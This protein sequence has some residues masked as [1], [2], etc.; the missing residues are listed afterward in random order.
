[1]TLTLSL[2]LSALVRN[3][4]Q[5]CCISVCVSVCQEPS[6]EN[7]NSHTCPQTESCSTQTSHDRKHYLSDNLSM[8]TGSEDRVLRKNRSFDENEINEGSV[9]NVPRQRLSRSVS[10]LWADDTFNVVVENLCCLQI[11]ISISS[12]LFC[13]LFWADSK[14]ILSCFVYF[15][16]KTQSLAKLYMPFTDTRL[17]ARNEEWH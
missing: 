16:T 9:Q 15:L 7:L 6:W 8:C 5:W 17:F 12:A 2:L 10:L 3:L 1:M 11:T 13:L 14:Y 4:M